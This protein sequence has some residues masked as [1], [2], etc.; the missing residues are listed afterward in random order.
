[1]LLEQKPSKSHRRFADRAAVIALLPKV[2]VLDGF[3][4]T[5][6]ERSRVRSFWN[7]PSARQSD[8]VRHRTLLI[9]HVANLTVQWPILSVQQPVRVLADAHLAHGRL[10]SQ[11]LVAFAREPVLSRGTFVTASLLACS[12]AVCW[13]AELDR[14]R[15]TFFCGMWLMDR[16]EAAARGFVLY[17]Q[18][19]CAETSFLTCAHRARMIP[20]LL[21]LSPVSLATLLCWHPARRAA[22]AVLGIASLRYEIALPLLEDT[23]AA[24]LP[25]GSRTAARKVRVGN[26][27]VCVCA[28]C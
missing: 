6:E 26:E 2:W 17:A 12:C 7:R 23:L 3:F 1:V 21:D 9:A 20:S 24:A 4:I 13:V 14:R 25:S 16:E 22:A 10:A 19:T 8:I 11:Y 28:W 5:A 27:C 18:L 15:L